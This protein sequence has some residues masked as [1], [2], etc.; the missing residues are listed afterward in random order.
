MDYREQLRQNR[1]E[2][3]VKTTCIPAAAGTKAIV[4]DDD[5]IEI[6]GPCVIAWSISVRRHKKGDIW[7]VE[8]FV[9]AITF[10]PEDNVIGVVH[11]DGSVDY[12][13]GERYP[14]VEAWKDGKGVSNGQCEG[15]GA[16]F[17]AERPSGESAPHPD[18]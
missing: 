10:N 1:Y 11:P 9:D 8:I 14:N 6:I 4:E 3:P 2:I 17:P 13:D 16:G 15:R 7:P 18:C 12:G 5:G